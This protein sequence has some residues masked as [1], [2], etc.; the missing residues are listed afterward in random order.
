MLLAHLFSIEELSALDE[1]Q[2][3]LLSNAVLHEIRTHPEL[4]RILRERAHARYDEF[5][6]A[7]RPRRGGGGST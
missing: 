1:K 7:R 6:V 3:E 5:R 2:L 4:Q